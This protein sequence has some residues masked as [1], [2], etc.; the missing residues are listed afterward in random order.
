MIG[1]KRNINNQNKDQQEKNSNRTKSGMQTR[2][3]EGSQ[4]V[5]MNDEK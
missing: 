2:V 1:A 3:N 5:K 4:V